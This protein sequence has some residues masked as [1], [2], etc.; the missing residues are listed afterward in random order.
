MSEIKNIKAKQ[1][2]IQNIL[3]WY[4]SDPPGVL[5]S[6]YRILNHGHL[7]GTGKL[8]V[9]P[10]DQG[11]EH[12][13]DQ[14]FLKNPDA[15]NPHYHWRLAIESGCNAFAA[16]L[17]FIEAGARCYAGQIPTIL[18]INS[19]D[20]LYK[21]Q[22]PIPTLTSGIDAALRLGC[23]AIGFTIYPGSSFR[24]TMYEEIARLL[25]D[26]KKAGLVIVIWSYPRGEGLKKEHETALDV[27]SYAAHI[28]AQLGAHIIKVKPPT[29][30]VKKQDIY[31]DISFKDNLPFNLHSL[32]HRIKVVL[33]AAFNSRRI[34]I[35]SGGMT[36]TESDL[37]E[38][39]TQLSQ[40]GSFGSIVGRNAFQRKKP[41]AISLLK[42][43]IDIYLGSSNVQDT[44]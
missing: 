27:V 19:S 18:K 2:H 22:N 25:E 7:K 31:K 26:A 14:S 23:A 42:K 11:F 15:Y 29:Y 43:I 44:Q 35:F 9:L 24:K 21:T 3:S 17:G 41:E 34:V 37:L 4:E 6:L 12:G 8:L 39:I 5:T 38:E 10:V 33:R 32:N 13:P 40:G 30:I 28:A 16:P 1:S 36:K 20:L